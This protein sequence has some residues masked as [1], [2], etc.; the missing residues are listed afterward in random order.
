MELIT[1][2][3][4]GGRGCPNCLGSG[5]LA[6]DEASRQFY[7]KQN[8]RGEMEVVGPKT[9]GAENSSTNFVD[10]IFGFVLK[11]TAE[12]PDLFWAV[13]LLKRKRRYER[14]N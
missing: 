6:V 4:C 8:V 14:P 9:A 3:K 2:P 11:I 1:C 10:L 7:V 12:P 13:K 5:A